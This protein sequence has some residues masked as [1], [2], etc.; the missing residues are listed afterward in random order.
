MGENKT[1]LTEVTI[2]Y[3]SKGIIHLVCANCGEPLEGK[4]TLGTIAIIPCE[5]CFPLYRKGV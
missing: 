2:M 5:I 1:G 4:D 3:T